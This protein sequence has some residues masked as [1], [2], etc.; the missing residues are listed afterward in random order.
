MGAVGVEEAAAV[1]AQHLD[2]FL[3]GHRPL[4]DG[5][6]LAASSVCALCIAMQVLR[7]TLPDQQQRIDQADREQHIEHGP[8]HID[9]EVADRGRAGPL[10]AANQGH[11][12]HD[13]RRRRPEIVRRQAGHLREIAHGGLGR[14]E[15]PVG[16]GGEAGGSVPGQIGSHAGQMLRIPRQKR[17]QALD[18][19]GQNHGDCR[20]AQQGIGI[21]APVHLFIGV[22]AAELVDQPLDGTKHRVQPGAFPLKDARHIS[23]HRAN[24][25]PAES[26]SKW[27]TAT[28]H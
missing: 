19:I 7:N 27:Q 5:L 2:G 3:R 13:A 6:G 26:A 16:I 15:L 23:A 10:D 25:W 1:G 9:P 11:G 24:A 17:L 4:P 12:H 28:S 20:Q 18:G 14:I 8:G 21:L 22:H